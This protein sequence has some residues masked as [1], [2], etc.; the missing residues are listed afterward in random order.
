MNLMSENMRM[1]VLLV[2]LS[3]IIS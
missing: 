3:T 1:M 2:A